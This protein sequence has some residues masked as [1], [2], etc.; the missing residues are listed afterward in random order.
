M[1]A[2]N[3]SIHYHGTMTKKLANQIIVAIFVLLIG[4]GGGRLYFDLTAGF[5]VGNIQSDFA[6][7][8]RWDTRSLSQEENQELKVA[9][10]QEYR[11]LGKGCQ[12]YAFLSQDGE[13]VIKFFKYQRFRPQEWTKWLTFIPA[14]EKKRE[15]Q[16]QHRRNKLEGVYAS[17]KIAFDKLAPE[18]GLVY[19][20]LNKTDHLKNPIVIRDKI[21][22]KHQVDP[23][24]LE[25]LIQ[26]RADMLC[27][28][29]DKWM[30]KGKVDKSKQLIQDLVAQVMSEYQRGLADNDHALMQNTGVYQ[31]KPFHI[32]VGQF[33]ESENVKKPEIY[34]K[35]LFD[36][37]YKFRIWLKKA[38]PEL[39][40]Y[41]FDQI[42]AVIGPE[43]HTM[44][45]YFGKVEKTFN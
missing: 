28:T 10:N 30:R 22:L 43:I 33:V 17:W 29:L 45:P 19:V 2:A 23:D 1:L 3:F 38:H 12:S 21:G 15:K 20:H 31:G 44:K 37:T 7:D 16:I 24:Q 42:Y 9:L 4:Y 39:E 32:D 35:E 18:S 27:S 13:Y 6:Y 34:K 5:T 41:L 11:Y 36:K 40:I 25:F 14:V 8:S 26:R